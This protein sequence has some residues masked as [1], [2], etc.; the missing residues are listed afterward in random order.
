MI[1]NVCSHPTPAIFTSTS[2]CAKEPQGEDVGKPECADGRRRHTDLYTA[3][4]V[5]NAGSVG[6]RQVSSSSL[7]ARRSTWLARVVWESLG[8][9]N[10]ARPSP[11]HA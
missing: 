9:P 3:G 11:T 4:K 2:D 8:T 7:F 1:L 5:V 10:S 6:I